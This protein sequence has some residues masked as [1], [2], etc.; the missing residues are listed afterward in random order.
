[1][2]VFMAFYDGYKKNFIK[3]QKNFLLRSVILPNNYIGHI[4]NNETSLPKIQ[5]QIEI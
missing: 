1:M 2:E 4:K 5:I 3:R